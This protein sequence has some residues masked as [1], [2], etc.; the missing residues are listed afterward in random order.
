MRVATEILARVL[1]KGLSGSEKSFLPC[2][3]AIGF[4]QGFWS[5]ALAS[6]K[7]SLLTNRVKRKSRGWGEEGGVH[8]GPSLHRSLFLGMKRSLFLQLLPEHAA[9]SLRSRGQDHFHP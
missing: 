6:Q 3:A 7:K 4:P 5:V 8:L 1:R 2:E 9:W